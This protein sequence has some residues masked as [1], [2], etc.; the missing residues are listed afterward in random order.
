MNRGQFQATGEPHWS[1]HPAYGSWEN[2]K[3]RCY[4]P[5]NP[6]FHRYGGRGIEVCPEWFLHFI[7]FALDMGPK[8]SPQ[9]SLERIDNDGNYEPANCRWATVSEQSLNKAGTTEVEHCGIRMAVSEWADFTGLKQGTIHSRIFLLGWP[10]S[11]A[12]TT[13]SRPK[14]KNGQGRTRR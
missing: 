13:P 7:V 2:M 9:H 12:L 8:P 6:R 5:S 11:R 1:Q 4:Q 10:V 3:A 14:A